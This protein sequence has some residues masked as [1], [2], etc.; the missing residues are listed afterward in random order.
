LSPAPGEVGGW[1][2]KSTSR[3]NIRLNFK[4]PADAGAKADLQEKSR[5]HEV[6]AAIMMAGPKIDMGSQVGC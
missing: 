6:E 5:M 3:L 1:R 4:S 2:R